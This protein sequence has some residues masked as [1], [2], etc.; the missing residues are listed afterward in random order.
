MIV[1]GKKLFI[2]RR[3]SHRKIFL[4]K[5]KRQ[6]SIDDILVCRNQ[7]EIHACLLQEQEAQLRYL[8][9]FFTRTLDVYQLPEAVPTRYSNIGIHCTLRY[10]WLPC[11][12]KL[13]QFRLSLRVSHSYHILRYRHISHLTAP[14]YWWRNM[15]LK[16]RGSKYDSS[17][18]TSIESQNIAVFQ[19][20]NGTLGIR[21]LRM[22]WCLYFRLL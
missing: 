8:F 16:F 10:D 6:S 17:R 14:W 3:I 7:H 12:S 13:V 4:Y 20:V 2:F 5:V 22:P 1:T 15:L 11:T 18:E 9:S 21:N 19:L